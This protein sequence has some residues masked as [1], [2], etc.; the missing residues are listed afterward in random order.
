MK[1]LLACL[2]ILS[3]VTACLGP[4]PE[5]YPPDGDAGPPV[6]VYLAGHGWHTGVVAEA[7]RVRECLPSVPRLPDTRYLE[8]GWGD[9]AY[10]PDPDS[11][12][13]TML[14]AA[15]L[16]TPAVMHIAGFDRP[17]DERFPRSRIVELEISRA[18]MQALACRLAETIRTD[19][20]GEAVFRGEGLYGE[21]LFVDAH[22]PYILP[23]TSNHWAASV[24]RAAGLPITPAW[25]LSQGNVFYQAERV[26]RSGP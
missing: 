24:L 19:D 6:T 5:L 17:P 18:G 13:L 22:G 7:D 16:P 25:A 3:T 4:V 12:F 11:G 9:A 23:F 10:Y 20:S 14:S 2:G 1:R 8:F 21:S 26:A 15:L